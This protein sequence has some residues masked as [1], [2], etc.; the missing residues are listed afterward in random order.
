MV[1][2]KYERLGETRTEEAGQTLLEISKSQGIPH[3]HACGGNARCS[4]CRVMVLKGAGNLAPRTEA[5]STLAQR[6]GLG[7]DIRLACQTRVNGPVTIQRL[8]LDDRDAENA[9]TH[10]AQTAI[11]TGTAMKVAVLF[12]DIRGF[13][14]F[15]ESSLPYDVMHILNRYLYGVGEAI[16]QNQGYIDKYMG[17]GVMAL[18]GLKGV[19]PKKAATSRGG[20]TRYDRRFR[21]FQYLSQR[22]IGVA[23]QVGIGVHVGEVVVGE[24]GHPERR[25]LTALGDVV[26]TASRI[27]SATKEFGAN[28][29]ISD[30]VYEQ[31]KDTIKSGRSFEAKLKGKA[32]AHTLIEVL[33]ASLSQTHAEVE[34]RVARTVLQSITRM[35]APGLLRLAFHDAMSG[36]INGSIRTPEA[37]A[38]PEN[39]GLEA[40]LE[41]L[42]TLKDRLGTISWGDLIAFRWGRQQLSV[43]VA[44]IY[45]L[46]LGRPEATTNL[47]SADVPHH[48]ENTMSL[49]ARFAK[50]GLSARDL[51]A[52][53]GA[54]TLGKSGE[55]P[56]TSDPFSFTN[57]Y[58]RHLLEDDGALLISDRALLADPQTR[59]YVEEYAQNERAFFADFVTAYRRMC[60]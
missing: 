5:E 53:S 48:D 24:M 3:F 50:R 13:T 7:D 47:D 28:L 1:E 15:S 25:Q 23:F 42:T 20:G 18:F 2:I 38:R 16:H 49:K 26:N 44:L 37:L 34:T 21:E 29:L 43:A 12:S 56:F 51:V 31:V 30:A 39:V 22:A 19:G 55:K 9:Y 45:P 46:T 6:K 40:P 57:S 59:A 8:V 41:R 32:S 58:F 36:G 11:G 60:D 14:T 33:G 52:L 27:E 17:D 35:D 4:T 10:E 54:H